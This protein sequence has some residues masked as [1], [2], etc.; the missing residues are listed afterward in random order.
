MLKNLPTSRCRVLS[1][2]APS[3]LERWT[4]GDCVC[5]SRSL[6]VYWFLHFELH[7]FASPMVD[8]AEHFRSLDGEGAEE[9]PDPEIASPFWNYPSAAGSFLDGLIPR[10]HCNGSRSR[11][12]SSIFPYLSPQNSIS[13]SSVEFPLQIPRDFDSEA[14]LLRDRL[15]LGLNLSDRCYLM[16]DA[17][18][19]E[20]ADVDLS[21]DSRYPLGLGT[22]GDYLVL[23]PQLNLRFGDFLNE[24]ERDDL[25][26]I[27]FDEEEVFFNG[28]SSETE[29]SFDLEESLSEEGFGPEFNSRE[30]VEIS[31]L[32]SS[33]RSGE[34]LDLLGD[35][36]R[37]PHW[38]ELN[39][40]Y[41][42][43]EINEPGVGNDTL[44]ALAEFH[45]EESS[46]MGNSNADLEF[47]EDEL[48]P[49]PQNIEWEFL[50]TMNNLERNSLIEHEDQD[51]FV[52]APEYEVLFGQFVANST[53]TGA[54]PAA[55]SVIDNL[56]S[57]F[58]SI[59]NHASCPVCKEEMSL[60]EKVKELP[61]LHHYHE[62]CIINW[63]KIR[64]TC[65]VCRQ[66]LPTDDT[67]N[68]NQRAQRT[69]ESGVVDH[70]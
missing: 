12:L 27:D 2:S 26:V 38:E 60:E 65:P 55:K 29:N 31:A 28:R 34:S 30:E 66:E 47:D 16:R 7:A 46:L 33:S 63:L 13:M 36:G 42:W 56:P 18:D 3:L 69:Q 39:E 45:Q 8:V 43:E 19:R 49:V 59:K 50:L 11:V 64:N 52:H 5:I 54:P 1:G 58:P 21:A 35:S 23:E 68:E 6:T 44:R 70:M 51:G 57:V 4:D 53:V 15:E 48:S 67:G 61:C 22:N 25:G 41:E 9:G 20:R 10:R 32:R 17:G 37:L 62:E 24:A 14:D 40:D